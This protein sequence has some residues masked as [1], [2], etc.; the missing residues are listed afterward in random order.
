MGWYKS[1]RELMAFKNSRGMQLTMTMEDIMPCIFKA[2]NCSFDRVP[3]NQGAISDRGWFPPNRKLLSHPDLKQKPA[4]TIEEDQSNSQSMAVPFDATDLNFDSGSAAT[5]L[6][7]IIQ[8]GLRTGGIE[9]RKQKLAEGKSIATAVAEGRK[10]TSGFLVANGS[11]SLNSAG[12]IEA[13][14]SNMEKREASTM[15]KEQKLRKELKRRAAIVGRLDRTQIPAWSPKEC[16]AF[17]QWKKNPT[18]PA[19]PKAIGDLRIRCQ[20]WVSRPS[21]NV[22][23]HTSDDEQDIEETGEDQA[24]LEDEEDGDN[25]VAIIEGGVE[26]TL[27]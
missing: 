20:Q 7:S 16:R 18:D 5:V 1:K 14:R 23:P 8:H 12:M 19:M 26:M 15:L 24:Q 21:P 3:S 6:E 17:L 10:L 25:G 9:K 27:I 22:S 13:V 4:Q 11:H 2:W